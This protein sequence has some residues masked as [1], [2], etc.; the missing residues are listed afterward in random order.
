MGFLINTAS[1]ILP[2]GQIFCRHGL[3]YHC[4]A[5]DTQIYIHT[6]PT[7]HLQDIKNWMTSNLLKLN[8]NKTEVM[9]EP[10]KALIKKVGVILDPTLSF[11]PYIKYIT[12]SSF[13]HLCNISRLR[14]SLTDPHGPSYMP[15]SHH[16]WTTAMES[17]SRC[18]ALNRLQYIQNSTARVLTHTKPWECITPTLHQL[19]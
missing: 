9:L 18:S 7:S 12:N 15:L 16:V 8:S 5:D 17:Y 10:P 13:F 19:H 11:K 6:K 14:P 1:Y 3:N 2:L 4:Y